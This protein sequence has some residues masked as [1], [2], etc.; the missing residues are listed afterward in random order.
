MSIYCVYMLPVRLCTSPSV[1]V[2]GN[3]LLL[4]FSK[5][6]GET[7]AVCSKSPHKGDAYPISEGSEYITSLQYNFILIASF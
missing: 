2:D 5:A 3:I 6:A 4:H 7:A 1:I